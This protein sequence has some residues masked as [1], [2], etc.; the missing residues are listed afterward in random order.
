[1]AFPGYLHLYFLYVADKKF[2]RMCSPYSFQLQN[3]IASGHY[4]QRTNI[5]SGCAALSSYSEDG[6]HDVDF[7]I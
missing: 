5:I 3:L 7:A 1:M 2:M 4:Y 6:K